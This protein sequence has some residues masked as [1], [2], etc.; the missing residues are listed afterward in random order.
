MKIES[1]SF[2]LPEENIFFHPAVTFLHDGKWFMTAQSILG[3]DHYGPPCFSLSSDQGANWE[4]FETIPPFA[5]RD[6]GDGWYEGVADIRPFCFQ[7]HPEVFVFG[8]T[9]IYCSRGNI[10]Y[11]TPPVKKEFPPVRAVCAIRHADGSWSSET[12]ELPVQTVDW[13]T[14]CIQPVMVSKDEVLIPFHYQ[15]GTCIYEGHSSLRC[16]VATV[17]Y[18]IQN[19][20]LIF[21]EMGKTLKLEFARGLIEPSLIAL[22]DGKIALTL[23]AENGHGY[24]AVSSDGLHWPNPLPWHWDDR[25]NVEMTSTQQHWLRIGEKILLAYTRNNGSNQDVFRCRSPLYLAEA[26]PEKAMLF[27]QTEKVVFPMLIRNGIKSLYGNFHV[28]Q[29]DDYRAL[30]TDAALFDDRKNRKLETQ[31]MAS[32]VAEE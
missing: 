14:T 19:G 25:S 27:R 29:I 13:R 23:R 9:S 22:P 26:C 2:H 21:S 15:T 10:C 20:K 6:L 18:M 3:P 16:G 5:D 28:S 12:L 30:I 17:K 8:C 11:Q 32:M 31:V 4:Q 24:A 1:L 7:G